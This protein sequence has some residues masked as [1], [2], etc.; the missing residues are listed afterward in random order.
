MFRLGF[1]LEI[2]LGAAAYFLTLSR[3]LLQIFEGILR[4]IRQILHTLLQ[5]VRFGA[6]KFSVFLKNLFARCKKWGT[7]I[8]KIPGDRTDSER[9]QA[10]HETRQVFPSGEAGYPDSGRVRDGDARVSA[11]ADHREKRAGGN[12]QQ[13][14]RRDAAGKQ[15]DQDSIDALG[16]DAGVE[17]VARDKLGMVDEGDIVFYDVGE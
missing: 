6:K 9:G 7:I 17:A 11:Q 14:H 4:A 3:L 1:F 5:P 2:A 10:K 16:T 12:S 8:G 13:L 15:P